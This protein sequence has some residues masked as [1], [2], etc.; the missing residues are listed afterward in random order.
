V[1]GSGEEEVAILARYVILFFGLAGGGVTGSDDEEDILGST[2][3]GFTNCG[4]GRSS[5]LKGGAI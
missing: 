4:R 1:T 3:V 5:C 2:L